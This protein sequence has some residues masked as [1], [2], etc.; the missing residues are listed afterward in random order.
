[1]N[2]AFRVDASIA[3]G[4]GHL[5]RCLTLADAINEAKIYFICRETQ[6]DLDYYIT[7]HGHTLITLPDINRTKFQVSTLESYKDWLGVSFSEDASDT[8]DAVAALNIDWFIVDHYGIDY[9]WHAMLRPHVQ[10]IMVIDDLANRRLDCDILVNSALDVDSGDYRLYIDKPCLFRLG[11]KY[12]LLRSEYLALREKALRKRKMYNGVKTL[13]IF[14]GGMDERN[15][16]LK[17]LQLLVKMKGLSI[18]KIVVVLG[19]G[20]PHVDEINDISREYP[21]AMEVLVGVDN[22]AELMLQADLSIGSGGTASWERCVLGLPS[23]VTFIAENQKENI[24]QLQARG[25]VRL[26]EQLEDLKEIIEDVVSDKSKWYSMFENSIDICDGLGATRLVDILSMTCRSANAKDVDLLYKWTND[27]VVRSSAFKTDMIERGAHEDWFEKKLKN[28]NCLLYIFECNSIPVGQVR[29]DIIDSVAEISYSVDANYRGA[30]I[31][32]IILWS[33]LK[34]L[35]EESRA[36]EKIKGQVKTQ[37]IASNKI[38]NSLGFECVFSDS[39]RNVYQR[40]TL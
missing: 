19:K 24:C 9:Q 18:E 5:M 3:I 38:F 1:M 6:L 26:W 35:K 27:P 2:V 10:N 25:A 33:A 4:L 28:N 29:F 20:A 30:G 7:K 17:V 23:L 14:M 32:Q 31:G 39:E 16:A 15:Y 12:A 21:V 22:M 13:L 37:N 34:K 40:S 11:P 8:I 36:I